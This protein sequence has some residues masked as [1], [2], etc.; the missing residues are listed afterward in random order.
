MADFLS[1]PAVGR[2]SF[3][4]RWCFPHVGLLPSGS[5]EPSSHCAA[6]SN[7][8]CVEIREEQSGR[9][10]LISR[11]SLEKEKGLM[12]VLYLR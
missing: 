5:G 11:I 4:G 3:V 6:C 2:A 10:S 12:V 9:C 7:I 8:C 1:I